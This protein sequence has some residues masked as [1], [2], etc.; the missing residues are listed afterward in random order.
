MLHS[1]SVALEMSLVP[2]SLGGITYKPV[3]FHCYGKHERFGLGAVAVAVDVPYCRGGT[4]EPV[5]SK[6]EAKEKRKKSER[7]VREQVLV[8]KPS[9]GSW[10]RAIHCCCCLRQQYSMHTYTL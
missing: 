4:V 1:R 8:V 7:V 5:Q 9:V 6:R 10:V 3:R 2:M